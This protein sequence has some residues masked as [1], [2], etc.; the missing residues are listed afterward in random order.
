MQN[1][2][3]TLVPCVL[4]SVYHV[5]LLKQQACITDPNLVYNRHMDDGVPAWP[6]ELELDLTGIAQGGHAVGR[7]N[8]RA[9]FVAGALPGERAQVRLHT[10]Q[11]AFARGRAHQIIRPAAERVASFCPL[12][13]TCSAGDWRWVEHAAQ[14]SYKATILRD[15]LRH[16]G[17]IEIDVAV[18]VTP[19]ALPLAYRTTAELHIDGTTLGYYLPSSRRVTEVAACCL[20]HPAL[21]IA[22]DALRPLLHQRHRLRGVALHCDPATG[23]TVAA[24]DGQGNLR[25]LAHRWQQAVPALVGVATMRGDHLVG[26]PA[27]EHQVAGLRLRV[28]ARSFFQ[29]NYLQWEPLV[30]RVRELLK[31]QPA[32]RLLDLYCGVG[33]FSLHGA[34]D[35]LGVLGIESSPSAIDDARHNATQNALDNAEFMAGSVEQLLPKLDYGYDRVVLDPPRSGCAPVVL[36]ALATRRPAII[37]YVSCHPGTLA[38]DCKHLVQ[39]GY[40][41]TQAETINMFPHTAHV[42]SIVVLEHG[43]RAG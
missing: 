38:R 29:I 25:G 26:T 32:A 20:H 3:H 39:A 2:R 33:L 36:E 37:V 19:A 34:Q 28:G 35:A 7:Y 31:L 10:R 24:L 13:A 42:E 6:Q 4:H 30:A 23:Q 9:V 16:V 41:V 43:S 21:N 5:A 14:L 15:Q 12:E 1:T 8:E 40:R 17:G 11:R 18:P 27:V 22:L